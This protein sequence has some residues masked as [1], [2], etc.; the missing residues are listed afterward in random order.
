MTPKP[1]SGKK[2]RS[3]DG[4]PDLQCGNSPGSTD[5]YNIKI[6]AIGVGTLTNTTLP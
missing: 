5:A 2:L 1:L 6:T 4:D 3:Q